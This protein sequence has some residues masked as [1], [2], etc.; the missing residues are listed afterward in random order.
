MKI[1][2]FILNSRFKWTT[3]QHFAL[4]VEWGLFQMGH[5]LG[6]PCSDSLLSDKI[7]PLVGEGARF[8]LRV[9]RQLGYTSTPLMSD[10]SRTMVKSWMVCR[11][12]IREL[13]VMRSRRR[14][15]SSYIRVMAGHS[16]NNGI[17]CGSRRS[18]QI[19]TETIPKHCWPHCRARHTVEPVWMGKCG[20]WW[21]KI[22]LS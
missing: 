3:I 5:M 6:C 22:Y 9:S 1:L 18:L 13:T 11:I 12:R 16:A 2:Y 19:Q 17:H 14:A 7:G 21:Y 15:L 8:G 10:P 4:S 20:A